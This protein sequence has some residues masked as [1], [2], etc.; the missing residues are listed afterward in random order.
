MAPNTALCF[1][2]LGIAFLVLDR[3][4]P[5][6]LA[7]ARVLA[8]FVVLLALVR[9]V[10]MLLGW[11]L[12]VD[13]WF[14]NPPPGQLLQVPIA[15]MA[16]FTS[17]SFLFLG[18][19]IFLLSLRPVRRGVENI[20]G[21]LA[22][23]AT[24][25][26]LSFCVT[27]LMGTPLLYGS[28]E[29]PMALNTAL[30]FLT[31]GS[32]VLLELQV[33][34]FRRQ[35]AKG[36]KPGWE[37]DRK[38]LAGFGSALAAVFVVSIISYHNTLQAINSARLVAHTHEVL[39][40]LQLTLSL[41]RDVESTARGFVLTQHPQVLGEFHDAVERTD[42]NLRRLRSLVA[43]NP[44]QLARIDSL[45][46]L[47]RKKIH[48]SRRLVTTCLERGPAAAQALIQT[49]EGIVAMSG[50]RRLLEGISARERALL[51]DRHEAQ[52]QGSRSTIMTFAL[53]ALLV[54]LIVVGIYM[55][56]HRNLV[57][58]QRTEEELRRTSEEIKDL[59]NNAPCGYHS[60]NA[61]GIFVA[62]NDTEL[63]WLG[64]TRD[65]V[66]G[67]MP[68]T[69]V[70]TPASVTVFREQFP[71][72]KEQGFVQDVE[73]EMKRKD[74]T[75]FYVTV[76]AT[77][78]RDEEGNYVSS[79]SSLF[80]ITERKKVETFFQNLLEAAP[81]AIVIVDAQG[82]IRFLSR[83][84][85]RMFGYSREELYNKEVEMLIPARFSEKHPHHREAFLR[86]PHA[87]PMGTG[88]ELYGLRKDGTEFPVEII[89]G[90]LGSGQEI[91]VAAAIRDITARKE[92]ERRIN[93]LNRD[94]EH[95]AAELEAANKELEAF[96]YSVSHDLRA[97]LRHIVG[98]ADLLRHHAAER[99]D[100][101]AQRYV[102][103]ISSS[104][105]HM[106][107]LIDDLLV[108]SRVGRTEMVRTTVPLSALVEEA[109]ASL[110][111]EAEGR[112]INWRLHPLPEVQGDPSLLRQVFLNLLSNAIK[113]TRP[114]T[115]AIIEVGS[116]ISADQSEDIIYVRDNGV[117]FDM[118]YAHKLFGVFQR[119]H[120][121]REFEG[122]GIGLANVR[123]IIVRHGG[124]VWAEG[125]P[126]KGATFFFSLPR[127]NTH[128]T[129]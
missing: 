67:K 45:E 86:N 6:T 68:I 92:I 70:L 51:A 77:A 110:R 38:I 19:A 102:E 2:A 4:S 50:I 116:S 34:D 1:L 94:L 106:G 114:I 88:I 105:K 91:L 8:F 15:R 22:L 115:N 99:L 124:R 104:A 10:E 55:V 84:A 74:G 81:D 128:A 16:L 123:R 129:P 122:T 72:F 9:L 65:E 108:F 93:A 89:L 29:I 13:R 25:I 62:I 47:I 79:R 121:A 97:P 53:L 82:R 63:R 7:L 12:A 61:E 87:R 66:V 31:L 78:I 96:S 48:Y 18:S 112:T 40:E 64:Y 43:D 46:P 73:L 17:A 11:D 119:L 58:R 80:D 20:A 98:F 75:T 60:L 57:G 41:V 59:Y 24:L 27:Y 37:V 39:A 33:N 23:V 30:A 100:P 32:G 14:I 111:N 109:I 90:P 76:N 21:L 52:V 3:P 113:Y 117:G 85:E 42:A 107:Q 44:Q 5:L 69:D 83:Q 28:E 54:V 125:E 26:G 36:K 120:S 49:E 127:S 126:D 71:R 56:V 95:R 101:K 35:Q 103:I 118:T